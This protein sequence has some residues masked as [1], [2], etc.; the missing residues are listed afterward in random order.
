MSSSDPIPVVYGQGDTSPQGVQEVHAFIQSFVDRQQLLPRSIDELARMMQHS[1]TVRAS[2]QI[3][4]FVALEVY[5][6]KLGEIQCLSV[7]SDYRRLGI[8]R[9]LVSRC[10]ARARELEIMELM[11]ISNSD[12]MFLACGFDYSLP[13]QKRAFFIQPDQDAQPG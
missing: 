1:F 6:A 8:G 9:E 5:S 11:A 7:D 4:G 12:E 10:V 3:I 2:G 13:N